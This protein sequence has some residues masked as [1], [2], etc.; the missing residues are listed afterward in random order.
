MF[1]RMRRARLQPAQPD[2]A[3]QFADRSLMHVNLIPAGNHLAEIA[4]TPAHRLVLFHFRPINHES[5]DSG[6]RSSRR[7]LTGAFAHFSPSIPFVL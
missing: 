4:A 7:P 6:I 5:F 3:Q 2:P 1:L